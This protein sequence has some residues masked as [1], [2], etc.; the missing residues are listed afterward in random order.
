MLRHIIIPIIALTAV[1]GCSSTTAQEL[2]DTGAS[3]TL[4]TAVSQNYT[5]WQ[6]VAIDGKISMDRLPLSPSLKI[7]MAKGSQITIS[8]RVPFL[9]EVGRA[10]IKDHEVLAINKMRKVYVQQPLGDFLT[11]LPVTLSD[12]QNL[13]LARAFIAEHGELSPALT[14]RCSCYI[15]DDGWLVVPNDPIGGSVNYGYQFDSECRLD[16]ASA[17]PDGA[18]IVATAFYTHNR[19]KVDIDIEA[20]FGTKE[21]NATLKLDAPKYGANPLDDIALDSKYKKVSIKEFIKS[22]SL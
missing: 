10:Q 14:D 6:T 4:I 7:F 20:T 9:G 22:L 3:K 15:I 18:S 16:M 5:P 13:L 21:Y 2:L 17:V 1:I 11:D 12:L 8:I 19:N